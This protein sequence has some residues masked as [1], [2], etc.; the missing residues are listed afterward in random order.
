MVGGRLISYWLSAY[1]QELAVKRN[2]RVFLRHHPGRGPH[3]RVGRANFP[4]A[5]DTPLWTY[6]LRMGSAPPGGD[7]GRKSVPKDV[8]K[9]R[10][11]RKL[12]FREA[13]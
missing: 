7:G 8:E 13:R 11:E 1:F 3:P 5:E 6:P 4:Y 10:L 2:G 12:P 9:N